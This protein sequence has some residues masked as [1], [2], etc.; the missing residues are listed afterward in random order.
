MIGLCAVSV[1]PDS[2]LEQRPWF[3]CLADR[4]LKRGDAGLSSW[5]HALVKDDILLTGAHSLLNGQ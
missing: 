2:G 3:C 4:T 5:L 1:D